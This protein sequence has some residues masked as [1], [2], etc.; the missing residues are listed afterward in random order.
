[1]SEDPPCQHYGVSGAQV[2]PG[3]R[4]LFTKEGRPSDL[5]LSRPI[6]A[7]P[8]L[9]GQH[10]P[11]VRRGGGEE[12]YNNVSILVLSEPPPLRENQR[13]SKGSLGNQAQ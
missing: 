7:W 8:E 9:W 5:R 12:S 11:S 10:A 3:K 4:R 2:K 6:G 13:T 1:M